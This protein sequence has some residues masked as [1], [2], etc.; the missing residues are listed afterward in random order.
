MY[1]I[2]DFRPGTIPD[3]AADID[4]IDGIRHIYFTFVHIVEHFLCPLG[5]HLVIAGM[6]EQANA[7]YDV[8]LKRQP[9]LRFKI[10]LLKAG[11][12][13][14]GY[15]GEF[16]NHNMPIRCCPGMQFASAGAYSCPRQTSCRN[17][18]ATSR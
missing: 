9:L 6:A 16:A 12:A 8:S 7:D 4:Y 3:V 2:F 11:T 18:P 1:G 13:A 14:E 17:T 5:P 10:L 15:D